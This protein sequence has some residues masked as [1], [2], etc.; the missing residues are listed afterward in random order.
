MI[1]EELIKQV[2]TEQR[3][4]LKATSGFVE[5]EALKEIS[6]IISI[7]HI[8]VVTGH[9][10]SGK[11]VLLS[12]IIRKFYGKENVFY[13]NFDDERLLGLEVRDLNKLM[14]IQMMLFGEKKIIFLDEIQ[15][16]DKWERFVSRLYNEGYKIYITGS[17]AK[18][19]SSE[20]ATLLTGRHMDIEVY[21]FSFTEF[22]KYK[23]IEVKEKMLYMTSGQAK[24]RKHFDMYL[25]NGGFP[26]VV[27][28]GYIDIL[29]KLFTDV[30]TKDVIRRYEIRDIRIM[31]E[32]AHFLLSNAAKEFSYNRIKNIYSLGSVHTAKNYAK[33]LESTFMFYELP[34]FSHA[35]KEIQ[36][37]VKK[38]FAVDNGLIKAVGFSSSADIGRLYENL[39]FMELKRR[40]KEFY[41]YKEKS[42]EEVDFIIKKGRKIRECIQ[43]CY[44]ID[45]F[46]T[47]KREISG[48]L[49]AVEEFKL[50]KGTIITADKEES[51]M[52]KGKKIEFMPLWKWLL[53]G[54]TL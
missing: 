37:R 52:E 20:L 21:P 8:A 44:K 22:L 30:I 24:L 35:V 53:K 32:V 33:Y 17:N 6:E 4:L 40:Q 31:D 36:G 50:K 23:G 41:Y 27:R 14:Q 45:E 9:R 54:K 25:H 1:N 43:V 2:L 5:R 15:N 12:Q 39:V 11:S 3:E 42:G 51:I 7:K 38:I 18:L 46:D 29:K 28:S 26:E 47:R 16:I 19:L 48:L 10:R 49:K 34:R 13:I